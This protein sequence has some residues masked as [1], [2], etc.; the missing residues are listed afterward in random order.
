MSGFVALAHEVKEN[1][2]QGEN[3]LEVTFVVVAIV[4]VISLD[5]GSS[6]T[7]ELGPCSAKLSSPIGVD[8][9]QI[10]WHVRNGLGLC[11]TLHLGIHD[12]R[13]QKMGSSLQCRISGGIAAC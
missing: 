9:R 4:T 1:V 3:A 12:L 6:E 8:T 7:K 10:K 5:G 2:R 13:K 11:A